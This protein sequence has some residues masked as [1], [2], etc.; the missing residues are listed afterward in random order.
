MSAGELSKS[1]GGYCGA[2]VAISALFLAALASCKASP[3]GKFE[4][5]VATQVKQRI[6]IGGA[7]DRNPLSAT[8]DNLREGRQQFQNYCSSCHGPDGL[9]SG[10]I[11]ADKM[12]PPVP[13]LNSP[14]VQAFKDGQLKRIIQYGVSPSGMPGWRETLSDDEIWKIVVFIRQFPAQSSPAQ[15]TRQSQNP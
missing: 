14:E 15:V 1:A 11:F 5:Y 12:S 7:K 9:N 4:T 6:T 13:P 8:A 2:R 10:V 3:P